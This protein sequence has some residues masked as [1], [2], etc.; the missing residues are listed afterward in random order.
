MTEKERDAILDEIVRRE[1]DM[2]LATP[3]EGGPA[4]CQQRPEV[5]KLMRLMTHSAHDNAF[6]ESYLQDL[7]DA[8]RTGRNFMVEKY[9][10]MDN[11]IPPLNETPLLDEIAK[12]ETNW[13]DEA[14][15]MHPDII[16]RDGSDKFRHYLRCELETLSDKSLELYGEEIKLARDQNKNLALKRHNWLAAKLGRPP[17]K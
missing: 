1:L 7:K 4:E 8:E 14:A 17:L 13:L 5:F 10:R 3:N 9:A 15:K 2:F 12:A 11:L 16:K 6:L